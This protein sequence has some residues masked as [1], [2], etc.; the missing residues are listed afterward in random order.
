MGNSVIAGACRSPV[1]TCVHDPNGGS[2]SEITSFRI[3]RLCT[4]SAVYSQDQTEN[5]AAP[6]SLRRSL[7]RIPKRIAVQGNN[8]GR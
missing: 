6:H 8:E 1:T 5:S 4:V 7:F 2:R 3:C